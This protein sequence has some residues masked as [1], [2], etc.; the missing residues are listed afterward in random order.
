MTQSAEFNFDVNRFFLKDKWMTLHSF[1][2]IDNNLLWS[3]MYYF[4]CSITV[5]YKSCFRILW[6][7]IRQAV[8][9]IY[10]STDLWGNVSSISEQELLLLLGK[11]FEL[12][13]F[14]CKKL[15]K[16][17]IA[18]VYRRRKVFGPSRRFLAFGFDFGCRGSVQPKAEG[19]AEGWNFLKFNKANYKIYDKKFKI[20]RVH[21]FPIIT[22]TTVFKF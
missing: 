3:I 11:L 2:K 4:S 10:S 18:V 6:D 7:C 15:D 22:V 12:N 13:R 19:L 1:S 8:K 14:D 17:L 21:V 9:T 5:H 16:L 20:T